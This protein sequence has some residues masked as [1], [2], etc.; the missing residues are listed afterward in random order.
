MFL[1]GIGYCEIRR[2]GLLKK[3]RRIENFRIEEYLILLF[4][5]GI[6]YREIRRE[7]LSK[8]LRRIKNRLKSSRG[9]FG[10]VFFHGILVIVRFEEK[11]CRR[12]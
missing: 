4:L 11:D 12:N 9:V 8:K 7:G 1:W 2:E 5:W 10:I 3:L 6:G